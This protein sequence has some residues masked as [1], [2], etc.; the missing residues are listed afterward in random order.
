MST[1][2][3]DR[4]LKPY[5]HY[6]E[7]GVE[8][9][10][11]VPEHWKVTKYS[12]C[13]KSGMGETILGTDLVDDGKI[14]VYSA[15]ETEAVFG[16]VNSARILLEPDDLIIPARGNSIGHVKIVKE[17]C[18]TTQTT[19]YSKP[20]SSDKFLTRFIWYTLLAGREVLFY[21]DRTAIPQITVEQVQSNKIPFPPLAEQR[22][23]AAF[24]DR[25]T[26]RLDTLISRQQRLIELSQEKRRA[27]I[28][29][30]VTRGLDETA[31]L[32]ESGVEW[33]GQ[34]PEHWK[35]TRLGFLAI[36]KARL[37]WKGLKADEYVDSG[38][39][40]LSTPDIKGTEIDYQNANFITDER[41]LESPE[42]MLQEG[43]V[44]IAKD[45]S[46]LGTLNVVRSL[47]A[48]AT[49]NSSIAVLRPSSLIHSEFLGYFLR[50]EFTQNIIQRMKGGMGVP[51]LFQD[52]LKRF[53]ILQ[54]SLDEQSAI[55]AYL[56]D[57]TAK[58]DTLI[59]KARRAI[60]LMK[61]HR[62]ALIAAA[63]TGQIDVRAE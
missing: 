4:T 51:H 57:E 19:I 6:K 12:H 36:V 29:H 45:G 16:Y 21:F 59:A 5:P 20:L 49:V 23:I 46:T 3:F 44:L 34:V 31:P 17:L 60:E 26:A 8:W 18:T 53:V 15:T 13:Y 30:A 62:S 58:I 32:K 14:V 9:L 42:I 22:A 50:S 7:S 52:D 43:D 40:F 11:Q 2:E 47:P 56:D 33:L 1:V 61:E 54:P 28:G 35:I 24:L 25:E 63:V 48:P 55:V 38:N 39:I 10:G 41:Y 27:L 37:G